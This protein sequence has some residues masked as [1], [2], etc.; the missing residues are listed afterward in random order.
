MRVASIATLIG[1]LISKAAGFS[2]SLFITVTPA[3]SSSINSGKRSTTL[4]NLNLS[5][6][7]DDAFSDLHDDGF[8]TSLQTRMIQLKEREDT[9]LPLVRMDSILPR[10]VLRVMIEDATIIQ[11][12]Q[13]IWREENPTFGMHGTGTTSSGDMID[14]SNGVEVEIIEPPQFIENGIVLLKL[15]GK[16]RFQVDRTRECEGKH[17]GTTR[18]AHVTFVDSKEQERQ[19][20]EAEAK[21]KANNI[22]RSS[23]TSSSSTTIS[24]STSPF[25]PEDDTICIAKA[26]LKAAELTGLIE[27]WIN[28]ARQFEL[29]PGQID[30]L[31][32][33]IG[34]V[35]PPA[36]EPSERAFWV[37]VVINPLPK[38]GVTKGVYHTLL[39]P[40]TAKKRW[41]VAY[42]VMRVAVKSF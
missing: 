2:S 31:L 25:R 18:L 7:D 6:R 3:P 13:T 23:L 30:L 29:R 39:M 14:L 15:K 1:C 8:M 4:G 24:T 38:M 35:P 22:M 21:T 40:T 9:L 32:E 16:R 28:L 41:N 17:G 33:D 26:V 20:M 12:I 11:L 36:Y 19:E 10:Q 37:G 42:G 5:N 27:R 34:P